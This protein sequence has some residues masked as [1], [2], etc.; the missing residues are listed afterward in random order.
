MYSVLE[1]IC[2]GAMIVAVP[3][4]LI[5]KLLWRRGLPWWS[6]ILA[7]MLFSTALGIALDRLGWRAHFERYDSCVHALA[8]DSQL[9]DCGFGTYDVTYVPVY[10]KW[11]LGILLLIFFSP[12][13]GLAV[14]LRSRR[15]GSPAA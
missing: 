15:R 1:Y 12:F 9:A 5:A 14:W 8:P 10:F 4:L 7:A 2:W 3:A 11:I 6:V 13:Y